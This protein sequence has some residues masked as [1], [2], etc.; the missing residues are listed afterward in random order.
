MKILI[1]LADGFEEVEA[2]TVVDYLRRVE[3]LVDMV[4]ITGDLRVKGAHG[5]EL[6]SD[7]TLNNI[8]D[9]DSYTGLVI[10]GG[11]GGTNN[12]KADDRVLSLIRDFNSRGKMLAAICAGP[13]VLEKAGILRGRRITSYP[14]L[15]N[16]FKDS[17]CLDNPVVVNDNIITSRGPFL[18][19]AFSLAIVDYF[20]DEN[21]VN[22][23][24][25]SILYYK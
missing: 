13:L 5:I 10:P 1:L 6:L 7:F 24:K 17:I 8:G 21:H 19:T 15:E 4:S 25:N 3:I 22:K 9:L 12:L 2:L 11:L 14:G 16:S 23:L 18:S 20:L